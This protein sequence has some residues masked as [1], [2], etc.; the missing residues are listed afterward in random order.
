M[1]AS[2]GVVVGFGMYWLALTGAGLTIFTTWILGRFDPISAQN[3][4]H[5]VDGVDS[6]PDND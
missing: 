2:I 3:H 6:T 4:H 5:G 1:A